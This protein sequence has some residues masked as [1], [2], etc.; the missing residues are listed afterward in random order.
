MILSLKKMSCM[1]LAALI[2][3]LSLSAG[4][5]THASSTEL[6]TISSPTS[7]ATDTNNTQSIAS[8]YDELDSLL[9]KP[10]NDVITLANDII[11]AESNYLVARS[12]TI[13]TGEY[14]LIVQ[15]TLDANDCTIIGEGETLAVI[16]VE[17]G[18]LLTTLS[19]LHIEATGP[20]GTALSLT[21]E[22]SLKILLDSAEYP[23]TI[24]SSYTG[25]T[26]T[27]S[28]SMKNVSICAGQTGLYA[29]GNISLFFC[30]IKAPAPI[31]SGGDI[32]LNTCVINGT[33]Q[34]PAPME[35]LS[36]TEVKPYYA[37]DTPL[38][39]DL[40]DIFLIFTLEGWG[41][42]LWSS[43]VIDT[44]ALDSS[45]TGVQSAPVIPHGRAALFLQ[46][47]AYSLYLPMEFID[48]SIPRY[49]DAWITNLDEIR[50]EFNVVV[51]WFWNV[52]DP[53]TSRV[54]RCD[55]GM[56]WKEIP[57][58]QIWIPND[59]N[60]VYE[61]NIRL[62]LSMPSKSDSECWLQLFTADGTAAEIL[63]LDITDH[64]LSPRPGGDRNGGDRDG[65]ALPPL[66]DLGAPSISDDSPLSDD[67]STT[68]AP[69]NANGLMI[70]GKS[71][72]PESE[73]ILEQPRNS[74]A[75]PTRDKTPIT[76]P[77]SVS[78]VG[79]DNSNSVQSTAITDVASPIIIL[80]ASPSAPAAETASDSLSA[81]NSPPLPFIAAS[82]VIVLLAL[83]CG[84]FIMSKKLGSQR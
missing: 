83:G 14:S 78:N 82:A 26:S 48:S 42:T 37:I 65:N 64:M 54:F 7:I 53:H 36:S 49:F 62:Q 39:D 31:E 27:A 68:A 57:P 67:P 80:P 6:M 52:E 34:S 61:D 5:P 13:H 32:D 70:M 75:K 45:K 35:F 19:N 40:T 81:R 44:N 58:Q 1:F 72:S 50:N 63:Y 77:Q 28:L 76:K 47:Q 25:I 51:E 9:S 56:V 10:N 30:D 24:I 55:D 16:A 17:N 11:I 2:L 8:T 60:S 29:T 73:K 22:N 43:A 74:T 66:P 4:L 18:G 79:S 21:E 46:A 69:P 12:A 3:I 59:R 71:E 33:L 20:Q 15:G 38:P 23:L 84:A 41:G